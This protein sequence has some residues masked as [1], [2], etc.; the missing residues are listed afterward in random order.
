LE[1]GESHSTRAKHIPCRLL[2]RSFPCRFL[3]LN[4]N[5]KIDGRSRLQTDV[6]MHVGLLPSWKAGLIGAAT[7]QLYSP[8]ECLSLQYISKHANTA[9]WVVIPGIGG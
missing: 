3:A 6:G 1:G 5:G 7:V 4:L 9:A 8:A 2:F